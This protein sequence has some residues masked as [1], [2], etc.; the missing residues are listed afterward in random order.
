MDKSAERLRAISILAEEINKR[1]LTV[2]IG[3]G[4]SI[5]AGLPSWKDLIEDLLKKYHIKTKDTNLIR[6]ASR[7]EREAGSL[8]FRE[9]VVES[10]RCKPDIIT[11]LHDIFVS[12]HVNLFIT[13]NYDHLLENSFGKYGYSPLVIIDDK[14]LPSIDPTRKTIVKLHGDLNSLGSLIITSKDYTKYKTDHQGFAEW[15]NAV[16]S[17]NTILFLG[18][19]FDDPRLKEVDEHVL[20]LF[21]TFRRQPF[22]LLKTPTKSIEHEDKFDIDLADF[23]AICEDFRERGF[24]VITIDRYDE[25]ETFLKEI[26][27]AYLNKKV[28]ERPSDLESKLILQSDQLGV[29]EQTLADLLDEK[30]LQLSKYARGDGRLPIPS[31]RIE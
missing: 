3:A 7:L 5:S 11:S 15:L 27:K 9:K 16:V 28:K 14:D 4:C 6:V 10:L 26:H 2:F 30:T 17:Q 12:L 29:L 24:F 1:R 18:T 19:S 23:D 20:G 13:T 22:I 21:D 8:E 25:I 31:L